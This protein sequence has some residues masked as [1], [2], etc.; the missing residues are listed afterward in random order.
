M[1]PSADR[2]PRVATVV[3]VRGDS[4]ARDPWLDPGTAP[5]RERLLVPLRDWLVGRFDGCGT[6][7]RPVRLLDFGCGDLLLARMLPPGF[8]VDG[9]DLAPEAR[10]AAEATAAPLPGSEVFGALDDIPEAAY[11]GVVAASVL[12]YLPSTDA[13]GELLH[14]ASGWL[15]P[16]PRACVVAT[17]V[18]TG[19]RAL[20][21]DVRDLSAEL[22]GEAG[23]VVGLRALV[24]S[25]RR[26][27]RSLLSVEPGH[28]PQ[29]SAALGLDAVELAENLSPLRRRTTWVL[30]P[31]DPP[32]GGLP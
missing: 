14:R 29:I 26:S 25:A 23:L 21:A 8:V 3:R 5:I 32:V 7:A 10:I 15:R 19:R 30:A 31:A 9:Y 6:A 22:V 2:P 18:V 12:Q 24:R 1:S 16:G 28:L 4:T 17:D 27:P 20:A 13:L 11:D